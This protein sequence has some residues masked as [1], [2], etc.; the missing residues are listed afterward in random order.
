MRKPYKPP[1]VNDP[2]ILSLD[3]MTE[4]DAWTSNF[5]TSKKKKEKMNLLVPKIEKTP[6]FLK[7]ENFDP[8]PQ[9]DIKFWNP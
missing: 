7:F 6:T 5:E 9:L 2:F 4:Q 1:M 3:K 8:D